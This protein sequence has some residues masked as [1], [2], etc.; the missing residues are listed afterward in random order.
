MKQARREN[1]RASRGNL[2][3]APGWVKPIVSTF[4]RL[5]STRLGIER[6]SFGV[7]GQKHEFGGKSAGTCD[8]QRATRRTFSISR[9]A[10][11][12]QRRLPAQRRRRPDP[13]RAARRHAGLR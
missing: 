1:G 11:F 13:I 9:W 5:G 4:F 2:A 10:C 8:A 7:T 12:S 6:G 3:I